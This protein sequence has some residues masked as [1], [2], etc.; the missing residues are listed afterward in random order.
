VRFS[1]AR[2]TIAATNSASLFVRPTVTT[3]PG[4]RTTTFEYGAT[5]TSGSSATSSWYLNRINKGA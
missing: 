4:G 5:G 2:Q 1:L 3:Y